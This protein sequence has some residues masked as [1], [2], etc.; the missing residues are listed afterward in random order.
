LLPGSYKLNIPAVPFLHNGDAA[1]TIDINSEVSEGD[2]SVQLDLGSVKAEYYSVAN[3]FSSRPSIAVLAAITPGGTAVFAQSSKAALSAVTDLQVRLN[4]TGSAVTVSA[5]RPPAAGA[6]SQ[7][8]VDVSLAAN[9]N[10]STVV[11]TRGESGDM[12]LV[13]ISLQNSSGALNLTP[14]TST[15]NASTAAASPVAA[16][17]SQNDAL[18]PAGE[19]LSNSDLQRLSTSSRGES[20]SS[21]APAG[22]PLETT[23]AASQTQNIDAAMVDVTSSLQRVSQAGDRIAESSSESIQMFSDAVDRVLTNGS[24]T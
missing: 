5:K 9:V 22:E 13:L 7:T 6:T 10:D 8:P 16:S 14:A 17:V 18:A 24:G 15:S 23:P 3:W 21:I 20:S 1:K 19:P 12:R 2:E 11:Q 4:D